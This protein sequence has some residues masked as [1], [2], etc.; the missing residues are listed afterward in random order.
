MANKRYTYKRRI[1][2]NMLVMFAI[3]NGPSILGTLLYIYT[4]IDK[5]KILSFVILPTVQISLTLGCC[6]YII[7]RK[8]DT[9]DFD[10]SCIRTTIYE[11]LCFILL[12]IGLLLA[13][14]LIIIIM[15]SLGFSMTGVNAK[16]LPWSIVLVVAI[17][18]SVASPIAEELFWRGY[19]QWNLRKVFGPKIALIGQATAFS[20][21]SF[22]QFLQCILFRF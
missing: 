16:P 13:N 22:P 4:S 7:R 2:E 9:T 18:G 12:V 3:S 14:I 21:T 15:K 19:I 17:E 8:S 20:L 10:R 11:W 6:V 1:I 5:S